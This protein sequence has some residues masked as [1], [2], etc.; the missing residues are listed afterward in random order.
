MGKNRSANQVRKA[1]VV[2]VTKSAKAFRPN[3]NLEEFSLLIPKIIYL[4]RLMLKR[5][6]NPSMPIRIT[7]IL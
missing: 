1:D 7:N 4:F 5:K 2:S 6:P 3:S